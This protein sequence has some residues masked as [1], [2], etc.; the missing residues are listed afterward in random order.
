MIE[1]L[2]KGLNRL[3]QLA[4]IP[5]K[6]KYFSQTYDDVYD[7]SVI[8]NQSGTD[9]AI[10]GIVLPVASLAGTTD[11]LLL[12]DGKLSTSDKKMYINGSI[13]LTGSELQ[14]KIQLNNGEYYS[15]IKDGAL[16][17][18][19]GGIPIYKKVYLRRLTGSLIGES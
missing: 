14:V 1:N 4:G 16:I 8:L 5:I 17:Y 12:E 18:E 11:S 3:T 10:S 9:L 15:L 7:D 13:L 19:A 2:Y 6:I